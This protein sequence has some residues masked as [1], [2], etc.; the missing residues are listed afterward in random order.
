MGKLSWVRN[1][2]IANYLFGKKGRTFKSL[3][4]AIDSENFNGVKPDGDAVNYVTP[5]YSYNKKDGVNLTTLLIEKNDDGINYRKLIDSKEYAP[6]LQ[7]FGN[8][9]GAYGRFRNYCIKD[10]SQE[11]NEITVNYTIRNFWSTPRA[12]L[13]LQISRE[14]GE[15]KIVYDQIGRIRNKKTALKDLNRIYAVLDANKVLFTGKAIAAG[16]PKIGKLFRIKLPAR[17]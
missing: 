5:S 4:D 15:I 6:L 11:G 10:E 1:N 17:N 12:V 2:P 7:G 13:Q 3:D 14:N 8:L 9:Y 16:K